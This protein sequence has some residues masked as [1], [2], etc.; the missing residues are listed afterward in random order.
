MRL[1]CP[2]CGP[3]DRREFTYKGD[4]LALNRPG[5]DASVEVWNDYLHNRNNP[6]G[7]T[8]ELWYHETGC[9]A[10]LVVTRD[11]TSHDITAIALAG[12]AKEATT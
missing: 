10:W 4:A 2:L 11:T 8:R 3:R 6:A 1:S 12:D 9:T 5:P 7:S